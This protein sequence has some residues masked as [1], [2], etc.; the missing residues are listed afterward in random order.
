M[1]EVHRRLLTVNARDHEL[2]DIA[3]SRRAVLHV[4]AE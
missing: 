4:Y 2:I 1:L 3:K